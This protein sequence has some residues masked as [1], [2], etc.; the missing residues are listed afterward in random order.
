MNRNATKEETGKEVSKVKTLGNSAARFRSHFEDDC[1][2]CWA[3][4]DFT[5]K[6]QSLFLCPVLLPASLLTPRHFGSLYLRSVN[7]PAGEKEARLGS[8][9]V[10]QGKGGVCISCPEPRVT[11]KR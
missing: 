10:V 5:E 3:E 4:A 9:S 11:T 1:V 6:R 2:F 7:E 8:M